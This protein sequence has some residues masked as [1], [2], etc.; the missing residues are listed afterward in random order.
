MRYLYIVLAVCILYSAFVLVWF[1]YKVTHRPA[2]PRFVQKDE[3]LGVGSDLRYMAA[4]DSTAVGEGASSAD[5]TY[6]YLLLRELSKNNA[7]IYKNV[8]V[9]GAKT[10]DVI[11]EQLAHI[12]SFNPD[13]VTISIGANDATHLWSRKT[14]L[15]NIEKI[16]AE[17]TSNTHATVYLAVVP[18]FK[19]GW[20]LP[21]VYIQLLE[22]R[23]SSLNKSIVALETDRVKVVNVHDYGW[24]QFFSMSDIYAAD[25][26]HPN[27]AGY[28]NWANAFLSRMQ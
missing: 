15:T 23:N 3:V 13:I 17:I 16:I 19:G 26:F 24:E 27:D 6:P 22:F 25:G 2:L 5:T 28:Q 10:Q 8:G 4:G 7:V 18:N 9:S 14:T 11:D 20:L 1:G 21:W 12:I